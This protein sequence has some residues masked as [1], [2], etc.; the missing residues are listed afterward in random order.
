VIQLPDRLA[1]RKL[2]QWA[3]AYLAGAWLA[4]Q[5]LDLLRETFEWSPAVQRAG[6]ALLAVGFLPVLVLAWYHGE[7]PIPRVS[8]AELAIIAGLL[9]IAGASVAYVARGANRGGLS[10]GDNAATGAV[11]PV[12]PL[13]V[14]MDSPHPARV[15]D[16][17]YLAFNGTNGDVL[18][19]VLLDLPFRRQ[20]K[21]I[22]H[23]WHREEE[24]R[25]FDPTL[26]L[27]HYSGFCQETCQDRTRLVQLVQY[28]A[29][30]DTQFLIYSRA[31]EDSL[32]VW[33]D[34]LLE[35]VER[36]RPGTLDRVDTFGLDD[37][38][39]RRWRDPVTASALKLRVKR[40][41]GLN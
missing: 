5:V 1:R 2:L 12:E 10:T 7:K 28:F 25:Q 16:P 14:M 31:P 20:K 13:V 3:A 36:E 40:I 21:A 29:D 18:S 4:L 33:V 11:P 30:T 26:I 35:P 19:D 38:G 17:E 39:S 22:G 24:I 37:H 34:A 41:L 9:I 15:Y 8:G 23:T 6:F 32:R 27:V